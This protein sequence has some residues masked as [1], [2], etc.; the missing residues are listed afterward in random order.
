MARPAYSVRF[1]SAAGLMGPLTVVVPVGFRAVVRDLDGYSDTGPLETAQLFLR[2]PAGEAIALL[3]WQPNTQ[4][5]LQWQGRQVYNAGET[6]SLLQLGL[7]PVDAT[8]S[9]YLLTA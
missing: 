6:I 8:L 3:D 4:K 2:G 9:G 5:S 1:L 7:A